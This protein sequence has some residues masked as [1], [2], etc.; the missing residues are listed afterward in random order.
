MASL[1]GGREAV[2]TFG[3]SRCARCCVQHRGVKFASPRRVALGGR[4]PVRDRVSGRCPARHIDAMTVD[5]LFMSALS[6]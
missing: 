3:V 4:H 5:D 6:P 1:G 2:D